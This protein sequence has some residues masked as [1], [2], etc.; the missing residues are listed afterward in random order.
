M[1][2]GRNLRFEVGYL[3]YDVAKRY[4]LPPEAVG[5]IAAG[6]AVLVLLSLVILAILRH[7]NS[8]AEREYKRIQLQMDTLENSVRSECKQ[9]KKFLCIYLLS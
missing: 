6:G 9:G 8:Q 7:K 4:E 1:R 2:V 5:S 3:K